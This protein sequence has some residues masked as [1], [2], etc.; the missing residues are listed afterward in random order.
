MFWEAEGWR[1]LLHEGFTQVLLYFLYEGYSTNNNMA[2]SNSDILS[3]QQTL[4]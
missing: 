2:T 4:H 3:L 1:L